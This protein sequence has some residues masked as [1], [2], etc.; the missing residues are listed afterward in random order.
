MTARSH[1]ALPVRQWFGGLWV[2]FACLFAGGGCASTY[3]AEQLP[4]EYVAKRV[5][6]FNNADPVRLASY[7]AQ[8]NQIGTGDLLEVA[9][10]SGFDGEKTEP[11][12][13]N[14][15]ADGTAN[16]PLIGLV[17]VAGLT[18][19][20]AQ[21][22]IGQAAYERDIVRTPAVSVRIEERP[23]RKVQV[24][25]L[26]KLPGEIEMPPNTDLRLASAVAM[27]GGKSE[28]LADTVLVIRQPPQGREP[29]TIEASLRD[30]R[31]NR[32]NIVLQENDVVIVEESPVTIGFDLL[33]K[34]FRFSLGSS[35][36]LF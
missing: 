33:Q 11:D 18:P 23:E 21:R 10:Y 25:G 12:M 14:V 6:R 1:R 9:V 16:V 24:S 32:G 29:I 26:V 31:R 34:F 7:S 19:D 28:Q 27:A 20:Q 36:A 8:N 3:Q 4:P 17:R 30:V 2:A 13:V 15:A 5:D 35:I 22:A